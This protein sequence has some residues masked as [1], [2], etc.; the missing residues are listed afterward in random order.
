M[1][2]LQNIVICIGYFLLSGWESAG[3]KDSDIRLN[4]IG[5]LPKQAKEI[6]ISATCEQFILKTG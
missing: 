5:F 1:K 3:A 6:T 2:R 4:F